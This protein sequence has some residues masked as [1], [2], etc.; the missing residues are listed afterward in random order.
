MSVDA[1]VVVASRDRADSLRRL[2]T[3]LA[4]QESARAFEVIVVDDGSEPP[5]EDALLRPLPRARLLRGAGRGPAAARNTGVGASRGAIVLFAD[6]DTQPFPGW[7][8]AACD[9]LAA[10]SDHVGVEGRVESPDWDP[11]REMSMRVEEP[12]SYLTAN[13]AYRRALLVEMGGFDADAFP[14]HGEDVD[15]AFRMMRRGPIGFE[16]RM[17][18]R[19]EPRT[20]PLA[21]M[22][23]RGRMHANDV[24]L[25]R[26][27]RERFGRAAR[28]PAPLF[29]L[30]SVVNGWVAVARADGV[31]MLRPDRAVR[32]LALMLG[33]LTRAASAVAA[34][35]RKAR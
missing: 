14:M 35:S 23:A 27:H 33:Q 32:W 9:F 16:P 25:F 3:A 6:D 24:E 28:L 18:T 19:H 31:R 11:L 30:V 26:R 17:A 7:L 15:L 21:Q 34:R 20:V 10:H 4:A 8:D 1:T 29:P 5:Y 12:G 22:I 2:V 13:I